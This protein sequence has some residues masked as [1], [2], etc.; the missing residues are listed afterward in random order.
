MFRGNIRKSI[1]LLGL[2][3]LTSL[4]I[5]ACSPN[6]EKGR[7]VSWQVYVFGEAQP[8]KNGARVELSF[9][10][11]DSIFYPRF[12]PSMDKFVVSEGREL[13]LYS[14]GGKRIRRIFA[15]PP[16]EYLSSD[17]EWSPQGDKLFFTTI[18]YPGNVQRNSQITAWLVDLRSGATPQTIFRDAG[19]S[20]YWSPDGKKILFTYGNRMNEDQATLF[21]LETGKKTR[22]GKEFNHIQGPLWSPD[23]NQLAFVATGRFKTASSVLTVYDLSAGDTRTL[24]Q[25]LRPYFPK[26]WSKDSRQIYF[27]TGNYGGL[28]LGKHQVGVIDVWNKQERFI[29]FENLNGPMNYFAGISP[30]EKILLFSSPGKGKN[31]GL[32]Q[33]SLATGKT[34]QVADNSHAFGRIYWAEGNKK[35]YSA[36]DTADGRGYIRYYLINPIEGPKWDILLTGDYRLDLAGVPDNLMYFLDFRDRFFKSYILKSLNLKLGK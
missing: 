7:P 10:R 34:R 30:D 5:A 31:S 17:P 6:Q 20:G 33:H 2:I 21:D 8:V 19:V 29:T 28:D 9:K 26:Y 14:S 36:G 16:G 32:W 1:T 23:G 18:S 35:F 27:E 22:I 13:W 15:A 11:E 24:A 4:L 25:T 3:I 12:N